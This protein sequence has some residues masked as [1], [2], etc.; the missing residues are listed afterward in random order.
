MGDRS[1]RRLV[2]PM[3]ATP[4][5]LPEK[6][7]AWATE[8]KWD[9]LRT[10]SYVDARSGV[11]AMS[12]N[13]LDVSGQYPE[14][15]ELARLLGR[16]DAVLDGEIVALDAQGV[17]RF[18]HLQRRM[19][20]TAPDARLLRTVPVSLYLFDVLALDGADTTDAPYRRRRHLLDGLG[21]DH[22][23]V[24]TPP[25]FAGADPADIY[26][27]AVDIHLEGVVCKRLD[28][29]YQPGHRSP[30]W[31]K[32]PVAL[33]QE[34]VVVG[35]QPGSGRRAGTIGA[36]LLATH[37]PD[38]TLGYVGKVGTGFTRHALHQLAG[39]LAPLARDTAPVHGVPPAEARAAQWVRPVLVGEVTFRNWTPDGRLRHP[40]W[41]GLRPDRSPDETRVAP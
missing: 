32:V 13:D 8:F 16:R 23:R 2:R 12:R 41:R 21:L 30:D 11:T 29:T 17:P 14:L 25:S 28:S 31:V 7:H 35:W 19:H 33:T 40:S 39:D 37:T 24:R 20:V 36:L 1:P 34:V 10:I 9:G 3:L 22:D 27:A 5:A 26:R 4:G 6:P 18:A 15:D 38:G